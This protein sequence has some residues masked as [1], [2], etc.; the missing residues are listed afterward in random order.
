MMEA[1]S[2]PGAALKNYLGGNYAQPTDSYDAAWCV[3]DVTRLI[4]YLG[5]RNCGAPWTS[6][7]ERKAETTSEEIGRASCRERV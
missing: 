1:D 6:E 7:E 2:R 3:N 4:S 5:N